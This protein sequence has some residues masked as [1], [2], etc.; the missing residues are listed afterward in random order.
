MFW[1]LFKEWDLIFNYLK[2]NTSFLLPWLRLRFCAN[3]S[4]SV[5][6]FTLLFYQIWQDLLQFGKKWKFSSIYWILV[7]W[8]CWGLRYFILWPIVVVICNDTYIPTAINSCIQ[9]IIEITEKVTEINRSFI[10]RKQKLMMHWR[11]QALLTKDFH[12]RKIQKIY[13]WCLSLSP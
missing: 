5:F 12:W 11:L 1:L 2:T 10:W 9:Q 3:H 8:D 6:S 7:I 13:S 4:L